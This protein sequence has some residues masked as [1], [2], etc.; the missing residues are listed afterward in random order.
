MSESE[1][2]QLG[3]EFER[4]VQTMIPEKEYYKKLDSE[5]I[6]SFLNQYQDKY[7]TQIYN[8]LDSLPQGS[9][10][11]TRFEQ[12]LQP[13]LDSV[14][15]ADNQN[16]TF[17]DVLPAEFSAEIHYDSDTFR[18]ISF[19]LPKNF[20]MYIRST[21]T[22]KSTY[23][24]KNHLKG[25]IKVLPNQQVSQSA[26]QLFLET[27]YN[28]LQILRNPLIIFSKNNSVCIIHDR[29]TNIKSVKITYYKRPEYFDV[30]TSTPCSLPMECFDD[31]VSGAV[32]LY[33]QYVAGAEA[34]KR[35]MAE[36][37]KEQN[38]KRNKNDE[39]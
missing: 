10:Q 5:T 15:I 23:S 13:L 7:I 20:Y 29:Y 11:A 34:R 6:Y 39:Q 32:D 33:V 3:I 28:S 12:I 31:L 19:S 25:T 4:R 38:D 8:N 17:G 22:V 16:W 36:A 18:S 37:A 30:M 27:P 26:A 1:T 24:F 35:R 2:R 9:K 21:S 14:E